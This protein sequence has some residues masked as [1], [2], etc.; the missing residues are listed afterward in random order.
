MRVLVVSHLWPRSDWLN[1]GVFVAD[2][3][4]SL[5]KNCDVSVAVPVNRT[6]R[7][8]E[9]SP[10]GLLSGF[11]KYRK[12]T[13]PD[14]IPVKGVQLFTVPFRSRLFRETFVSDTARN[15]CEALKHVPLGN[16]DLVHAHTVFPDGLACTMWL[17]G[18]STPLVITAHGSDVH[19]ASDSVKKVLV[20]FL[21]QAEALVPVSRFLADK[22]VE[23]GIEK[24]QIHVISNGFPAEPFSDVDD[25]QRNPRKLAFLGN[26]LSIK[27]VDLL[28][29]ALALCEDDITLDIAGDG[30]LRKNLEGLVHKLG[31]EKRI[32]FL[33]VI[34]REE[35]PGFLA[36]A[37]LMCLVSLREGWPTVIFEALACGT[38]VLATAVGG[39]PEALSH[40]GLG[41]LVPVDISP[42]SLAGEIESALKFEWNRQ[43]IAEYARSYSWDEIVTK[44]IALYRDIAPKQSTDSIQELP[45]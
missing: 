26:L 44:L 31:L 18:K 22:M 45:L 21:N 11:H 8:S 2:Q 24:D 43:F 4:S 10:G 34:S 13:R 35:V 37:S 20:P 32:R 3:V 6:I 12:R 28:I 7:R 14:L 19:S 39:V 41:S 27:R 23:F 15:L 40:P 16:F 9:L 5:A 30:D 38:P 33:G 1:Y 29:R 36:G 25:S 42:E 17:E